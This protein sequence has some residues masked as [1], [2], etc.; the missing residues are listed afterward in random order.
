MHQVLNLTAVL[1][2]ALFTSLN[3]ELHASDLSDNQRP[4]I[5]VMLADD[6]G[7]GEVQHLNPERG[8]I[9]TPCLDGIAMN[10][11][12]FTDGH[13][14]SSVCTPTRYGLL[15]GRYAWRTRLQ[16]GVLTGGES[17]IAKDRLTI[18]KML[19][20]NGYHTACIGKWH[21]GMLYDGKKNAKKGIPV[22]SVVSHGPIDRGGFDEFYGF[23]HARQMDVWI[24]NQVVKQRIEAVDML[25]RLTQKAVEYIEKRKSDQRPFFLYIPW[26]SPHSP[27]VPTA[28][29]EGKSGLNKHA[30]FVMQTDDSFG[31]VVGALKD[32]GFLDN[33]LI[34]C[35]SDNG[36]SAPTSEMKKLN[37]MGHF[38]SANLR[39]SKADIWDGGHRVPF[40]VHWPNVVKQG[41]RCDQLVCLTDMIATAAEAI[42]VSLPDTAAEDSISFLPL[43]KGQPQGKRV[44][45]VHHSVSGQFAI[46][47][48]NWKL[49]FCSGSGGWSAP[50][51]AQA[52]KNGAPKWQLYNFDN[53][54][55]ELMNLSEKH[56]A[57]A[58][59]LHDLLKLQI[60]RGRSTPG[61]GLKNDVKVTIEKSDKTDRKKKKK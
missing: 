24:E 58:T 13:S 42:D 31:Q 35:S 1:T 57:K 32:N 43:L 2:I 25:P 53:E 46:R 52:K 48:E 21:L 34:V 12:V 27:V 5:V 38:P 26:N 11:M 9:A 47:S 16:K 28:R 7:F 50:K 55:S 59:E 51:D 15:T 22:G 40:I 61:P 30:D 49:A 41:A 29:W 36:T 17:L 20:Q 10:G 39:G 4:N 19:K 37:Q 6:M 23:H 44:N 33:T 3:I 54:I 60:E 56:P 14:G 18:A 8:K 45:V